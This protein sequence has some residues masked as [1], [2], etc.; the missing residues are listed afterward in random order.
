M[1][2]VNIY[3]HTLKKLKMI[4]KFWYKKNFSSKLISI[5]MYPFSV[6]WVFVDYF[7]YTFISPYKSS[8]KVICVGNLNIGGGGKTPFCIMLFKMIKKIG[9]KP[10]F[11]TSGYK[12]NVKGPIE[13]NL[14]NKNIFF[15]DEA[16][17]LSKVGPTIVSNSKKKRLSFY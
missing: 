9:L 4:N 10:V 12:G 2:Q 15:G 11:L 17:I 6:I 1:K 5:F 13:V 14:K 3:Y 8:L 16:I 7:K